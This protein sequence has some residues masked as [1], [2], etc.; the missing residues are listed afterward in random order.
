MVCR[1]TP[2]NSAITSLARTG[3][4]LHDVQVLS[5]FH[6]IRSDAPRSTAPPTEQ[7]RNRF[8]TGAYQRVATVG[9][10]DR[11]REDLW[12]R[13][14]AARSQAVDGRTFYAWR[15]IEQRA[16]AA[17]AAM[18]T[19]FATIATQHGCTPQQAEEAFNA[20]MQRD[21]QVDGQTPQAPEHVP[22]STAHI[23]HDQRT[24]YALA[25]LHA[26][27]PDVTRA[28]SRLRHAYQAI[29]NNSEHIAHNPHLD[30]AN[31]CPDCGQFAAANH[32]CPPI[33]TGADAEAAARLSQQALRDAAEQARALNDDH[34]AAHDPYDCYDCVE[35]GSNLH[36][37]TYNPHDDQCGEE[38]RNYGS[39]R[40]STAFSAAQAIVS[41]N[42]FAAPR[43]LTSEAE[44]LRQAEN[45]VGLLPTGNWSNN[46]GFIYPDR[47]RAV[48]SQVMNTLH[49]ELLD[50]LDRETG[51]R[52]E[53]EAF[54]AACDDRITPDTD[55]RCWRTTDGHPF[56]RRED[57]IL[58]QFYADRASAQQAR[59]AA[60]GAANDRFID[61]IAAANAGNCPDCGQFVGNDAHTC[62][63]TGISRP[64]IGTYASPTRE[65]IAAEVAS[66][67]A[68]RDQMR[69]EALAEG[70]A[71]PLVEWERDLIDTAPEPEVVEVR[72]V[73][74][75][76]PTRSYRT[77]DGAVV[78]LMNVS[79]IRAELRG[80]DPGVPAR[81][82][83]VSVQVPTEGGAFEVRGAID[84]RSNGQRRTRT[85]DRYTVQPSNGDHR[86][87]RCT[88]PDYRANYDCE[89]VRE[90][91]ERVQA[92]LN[93]RDP[94]AVAPAAAMESVAA[95][96][97]EEYDA[98]LA[99]S[100]QARADFAAHG[101]NIAF[102]EDMEAFQSA[103]D[104]AKAHF[105]SG[106]TALPYMY[107]NA[108]NGLAAREG[109]RSIGIEIEVDFPDD[110]TY[111]A[112]HRVAREIYEAGLSDSDQ[113][114]PWHWRARAT[115][116]RGRSM[117][118]GYTDNPNMWSVEF[119]RSV[120][121]LNGQRGCEIV[122][123][124]LYD[125]PDTWRNLKTICDI[126]ER[127]GGRATPRTGLHINVG[128]ADFD[129][130]VENHNRL[131]GIA[132]AYEDVIVRTAHNPQSGRTHRG[133]DYCRPMSMPAE[134]FTSIRQA[135]RSVDPQ[136]YEGSSHRAMINLDHVPA[137]GQPIQSSTRVEVR[138]FDGTI[139]PGRIQA[140][141]KLSLGMVNAAV[142]GAEVPR[143]AERAGTHRSRNVGAN[144]R[145]R[146]LRGAEW[147]ADTASFRQFADTLFSRAEDKKQLTYAFAASR[148][149]AH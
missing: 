44:L 107:E 14:D 145:M 134:G 132:N 43:A 5:L 148:W 74:R 57:A 30:P 54:I 128:A 38:I 23:P 97:R 124:I 117:G 15:N 114:R 49:A 71:D 3:S 98:S 138:I 8:I 28:P 70:G 118:G 40:H 93:D 24:R 129:H 68:L 46:A 125:T 103:W 135:Q 25:M 63:E 78:R 106:E 143:D 123:P 95:D 58:H 88:C 13:F 6:E 149:Q 67:A 10:N 56:R 4:N 112:K 80:A 82:G 2:G 121:G 81:Y 34:D 53:A 100:Q 16:I 89:H 147:E 104:E 73:R 91:L 83:D 109:G 59:D 65:S 136:N 105:E 130:T 120:D 133:R 48:R 111:E 29:H 52:A 84:V 75:R 60:A 33:A 51:S 90:A 39:C 19:H 26:H 32:A 85:R 42:P 41:A 119:D 76:N 11:R 64:A 101:D 142:R 131:I 37:H 127:N 86:T 115:D 9:L 36:E 102:A 7:E 18:D 122:S 50:T 140:S 94:V 96:L 79:A 126:I 12:R 99:A 22:F 110:M 17:R 87:L 116:T 108:T 62:P 20:L 35:D 45:Q 61:R 146:R 92:L 137:E 66:E 144:G 55:N 21:H 47:D 139:D 31:Q 72:P 69:D 113:V 77:E 27:G 1:S 141:A